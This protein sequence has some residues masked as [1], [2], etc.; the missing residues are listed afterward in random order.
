AGAGTHTITYSYTDAN[1]CS[2]SA[3]ED[4]V[5]NG[6]PTANINTT[7]PTDWCEGTPINVN[8][9]ADVAESYQWL[10]DGQ[11]ITGE[12]GQT[13]IA[14]QAGTYSV[15]A[16][17]NGCSSTGNTIT[18]TVISTPSVAITTEDP[19]SWCAGDEVSVQL[20]AIPSSGDS[21]RW[22]KDEVTIAGETQSNYTANEPGN[23]RVEALFAGGCSSVS[24]IFSLT[25]N[26]VPTVSIATDTIQIDT[27][28]T[29]TF[30][31]GA[32]FVSYLWS[33][34]STGQTLLV[35]GAVTGTGEFTYWV[36]VTNEFS[37]SASDTAV[38][39]VSPVGGVPMQISWEISIYP[40]PSS[41]EFKLKVSGIEPGTYTLTILNAGGQIVYGSTFS[42]SDTEITRA[43]NIQTLSKGLYY[44]RFENT[45]K[46]F[47]RKI[48][49]K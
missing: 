37:C 6:L 18:I 45:N 3:S 1:G 24:E 44:V 23:Y 17:T 21:Y 4:M 39:V 47:T 35:D 27:S 15:A 38:V 5:V 25:E 29:Y 33:D 16:T 13:L 32:G 46:G 14:T 30:D 31:A 40:N 41:G 28:S 43:I 36:T 10:L 49:L 12:T 42:S 48:I 11:P 20:T 8:L 2:A 7:D 9:T 22:I 19:T 34:T 26:P